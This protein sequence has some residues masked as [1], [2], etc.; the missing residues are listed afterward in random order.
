MISINFSNDI[1]TFEKNSYMITGYEK[2]TDNSIH[3]S[4]KNE[5]NSM[6]IFIEVEKTK[7]NDIEYSDLYEL[8]IALRNPQKL[9]NY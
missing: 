5:A 6:V 3:L 4:I 8:L 9:T 2:I 7:V 1:L